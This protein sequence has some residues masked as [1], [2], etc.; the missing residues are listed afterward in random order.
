MEETLSDLVLGGDDA[1]GRP[2]AQRV[3]VFEE[4]Y[5]Y[6]KEKFPDNPFQQKM[7]DILIKLKKKLDPNF[8]LLPTIRV[9]YGNETDVNAEVNPDDSEKNL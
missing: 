7:E 4:R 1:L 9:A 2:T 3:A 5:R 6:L 8:R